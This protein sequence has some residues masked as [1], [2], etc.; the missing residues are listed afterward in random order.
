MDH[1]HLLVSLSKQASISSTLRDVK[2]NSSGWVHKTFPDQGQFAWQ[3]GYGAFAVSYSNLND[4]KRYIAVQAEHHRAK[5]FKE[6]FIE[7]LDKHDVEYNE[8]YLWE[9]S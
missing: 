9:W 5:S 3:A 6:E 2:S 8:K 4:V 1:V 7:F